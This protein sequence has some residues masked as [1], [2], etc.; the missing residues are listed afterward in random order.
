MRGW[1]ERQSRAL[2]F[3][4]G[5]VGG[6]VASAQPIRRRGGT[7]REPSVGAVETVEAETP[8]TYV[9]STSMLFSG[10]DATMTSTGLSTGDV[11]TALAV[12]KGATFSPP[13]GWTTLASGVVTDLNY[14]AGAITLAGGDDLVLS[15]SNTTYGVHGAYQR[16][17]ATSM[18]A[19][20][21]TPVEATSVSSVTLAVPPP[22]WQLG[23]QYVGSIWTGSNYMQTV[24]TDGF[25][26]PPDYDVYWGFDW[27]TTNLNLWGSRAD[28]SEGGAH[29][30]TL[31]NYA[32]FGRTIPKALDETVTFA[33]GFA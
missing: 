5:H 4:P 18:T 24:A 30:G 16:W 17:T 8:P 10:T 12:A 23:A 28:Q 13:A 29:P 25:T 3:V 14:W 9:S 22:G 32:D 27:G 1:E 31:E 6:R 19:S 20:C 15:R 11:M 26:D 21:T 33:L 2:Q 7:L